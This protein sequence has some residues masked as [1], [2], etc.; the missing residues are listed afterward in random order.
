P[1]G[2][3]PRLEPP[4]HLAAGDSASLSLQRGGR[5][6]AVLDVLAG[7]PLDRA[8]LDSLRAIG[9]LV[10]SAVGNWSLAASQQQAVARLRALD[11]LKTVFLGTASHELRTPATAIGG[12]ASLLSDRW[13]RFED[14][15]RRDMAKRIAANARSL[16]AVVQDLL[17]FS[18]L[19]R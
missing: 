2:A 11:T 7:G 8:D 14:A 18:L 9:G 19:D 16:S 4:P 17:D 15:E 5:S 1:A 12:F 13:D 6:V 10:A 3:T